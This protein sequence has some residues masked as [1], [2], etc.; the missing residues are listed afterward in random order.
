MSI[1]ISKDEKDAL[2]DKFLSDSR[3]MKLNE[4]V[5][6]MEI[7]LKQLLTEPGE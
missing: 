3:G 5:F 4:K 6:V 2:I 7:L 1:I